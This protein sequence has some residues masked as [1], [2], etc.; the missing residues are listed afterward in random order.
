M[1]LK[2]YT[3]FA[4]YCLIIVILVGLTVILPGCS[5]KETVVEPQI[6][7]HYTTY[8]DETELFSVS[9][10]P[11]WEAA[12]SLIGDIESATKE[13]ISSIDSDLPLEAVSILFFSGKPVQ[14][15]YLPN[16]SVVVEPLLFGVLTNDGYVE[17]SINGLKLG[18][19]DFRLVSRSKTIVDGRTAAILDYE[20]TILPIGKTHCKLLCL[21][22]G[23]TG[24]TLTCAA[25]KEEYSVWEEDF[26][27]I[28]RSLRIL[29]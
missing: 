24:W 27:A 23:R 6:P 28:A 7:D 26:N 9:Y 1:K 18:F 16:M 20:A 4:I 11:E 13:I 5:Q 17:A 15:G 10:P 14:E 8:T 19:E 25:P 21:I 12:L 3:Q 29:K 2:R 22:V